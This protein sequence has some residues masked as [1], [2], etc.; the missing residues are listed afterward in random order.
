M[1]EFLDPTFFEEL[2]LGLQKSVFAYILSMSDE[3]L[4]NE[5]RL[6]LNDVMRIIE[7]LLSCTNEPEATEKMDTFRLQLAGK[8]LRSPY[9]EKRLQGLTDIREFISI[10]GRKQENERSVHTSYDEEFWMEAE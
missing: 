5:T 7:R 6:T 9:L 10:V 3:E 4:K 2:A 8:C 1:R